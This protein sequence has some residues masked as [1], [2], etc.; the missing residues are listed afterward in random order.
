MVIISRT[1]TKPQPLTS[2]RWKILLAFLL[3]V[4]ASFAVMASLLTGL[5]SNY[6]YE[7]RIRQD[8]LLV[9]RLATTFAPLF[10]SASSDAV[11]EALVSAAG[12]T[13]GRLLLI[14]RDG[15]VQYDSFSRLCGVRL[16]LPEVLSVLT[17]GHSSAYGIHRLN[18]GGVGL[19]DSSAG[20]HVAY[21]A[22]ELI[23]TRGSLGAVLLVSPVQEMMASLDAVQRQLITVFIAVAA[24]ALLAALVFARVI[25]NPITV[26]TRAIQRM[27]RGDLSVRV[28]VRASG[29]M[30]VLADSYNAM[31]EQIENLDKS[32]NQFVSNASH[33]LKTPLTTMKILLENMIYQPEMPAELRQEFMTDMNHE[34][35]R[36]TSIIGDLLTLTQLDNHRLTLKEERFDLSAL[37]EETLRLLHPAAEKRK[38]TLQSRIAPEVTLT[39][40][41]SK[42]SQ[43][44][45]NLTENALKYTPDGGR[46][47]VTLEKAGQEAVL[48]VKDNGVGIPKE[49][50]AHIFDRFYRVDKARSRETG[51][52]GLGLSI[53]RQLVALHGGTVGVESAPKEGSVF[54]VRLPLTRKE[55][56]A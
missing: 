21:C 8:S 36:L 32:R 34:I 25:T 50:Q 3:I 49:D 35:D 45:Y 55:G 22:A 26:L 39:G 38:Q 51:G 2:I 24:A 9:E 33:E 30:R 56:A 31:A 27:G 15:K 10:Q 23:G 44:I 7:Q 37:T 6:L 1:R 48:T 13:G 29:E 42:L 28:K 17:G 41:R 16:S 40:D 54:T 14:D 47:D 43:V 12:E 11:N 53:V 5:V 46:I 18:A 52:T 20:V 19:S 4:G